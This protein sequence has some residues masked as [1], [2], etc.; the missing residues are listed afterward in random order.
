VESL[1]N[2]YI[3]GNTTVSSEEMDVQEALESGATALFGEKY[4]DRVRVVRVGE[5][6]T[7]L[8][9]GTHV[10]ASGDIGLFKILSEAGIAAG[11]RR[12]EAVTGENALAFVRQLQEESH[13]L[14]ALLK[15]EGGDPVERVSRLLARQKEL[16]R[17]VETLKARLASA[18][19]DDILAGVREVAGVPVLAVAV[20]GADAKGLRE[21]ADL[22]KE[23]M[24]SGI[25]VL[26]AAGDGRANLLVA[27]TKDLTARFRAGDIIKQLAPLVGGNGGGKPELAQAG[28]TQPDRLP[29]ALEAVYSLLEG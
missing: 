5:V 18:A 7:E 27:V 19:S 13:Q 8:C 16:Q 1:V 4:G 24:G 11:V 12:I 25:V 14:A 28:G 2:S 3:L 10:S 21:M 9:G 20:D 17:E 22:L 29:A 6:S 23:R 15:A 26:G